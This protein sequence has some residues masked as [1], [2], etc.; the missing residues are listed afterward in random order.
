M[1]AKPIENPRE[2]ELVRWYVMR[3]YKQEKKAEECLASEAGLPYF[4]AKKYVVREY[5]GVKSKHLVPV[6]PGMVFVH[7]SRAAIVD[8]KRG[9]NMLQFVTWKTREG[10]IEYLWVPE[11]QMENFIRVAEQYDADTAYFRPDEIANLEAGARVR[12]LGGELDG[13][14]GVFMRVKG[15]R[16]KRLVVV[17]DGIMAAA[18]EVQPELI[19]VIE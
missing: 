18:T 6:I 10:R 15:K 4:I 12:I 5:H 7:A 1:E 3:A 17:L 14:C 9:C 8:F 13:V 2:Q 19:E 16:N 11:G